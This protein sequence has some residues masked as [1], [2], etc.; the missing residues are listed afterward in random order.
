VF[1]FFTATE[2]DD[3]LSSAFPKSAAEY[4][5]AKNA[6]G[7]NFI[8]FIVGCL[9]SFFYTCLCGNSRDWLCRRPFSVHSTDAS[10][11]LRSCFDRGPVFSQFLWHQRII[12]INV[13]FT[14]A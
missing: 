14:L 8:A 5:F 7:S 1:R 3:E 6:F 9:I 2:N 12:W 13:A 4:V 11:G 10:D